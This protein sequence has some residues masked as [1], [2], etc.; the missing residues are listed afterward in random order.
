MSEGVTVRQRIIRSE[1]CYVSPG[2]MRGL[3]ALAMRSIDPLLDNP[4]ALA[5]HLLSEALNAN[6]EVAERQAKIEAFFKDL[7]KKDTAL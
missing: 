6:P 1:T 3:R 4:D 5:D 7:N 2:V